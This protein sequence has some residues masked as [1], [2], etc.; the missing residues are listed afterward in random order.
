[1]F[2][3]VFFVFFVSSFLFVIGSSQL[4]FSLSRVA[5]GGTCDIKILRG[6]VMHH[7]RRRRLF[8]F[9]L[10]LLAECQADPFRFEQ[11]E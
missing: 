5:T 4:G 1:M 10:E 11:L 7:Q 8:R 2:L 3:T 9:E 6:R